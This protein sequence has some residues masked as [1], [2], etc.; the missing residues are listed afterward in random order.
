[1]CA[2]CRH[3]WI[4]GQPCMMGSI[5]APKSSLCITA[6]GTSTCRRWQPIPGRS[7]NKALSQMCTVQVHLG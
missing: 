3:T 5:I 1:M 6:L 4:V 7:H 2:L